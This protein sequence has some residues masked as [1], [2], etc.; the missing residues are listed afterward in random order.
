MSYSW[1]LDLPLIFVLFGTSTKSFGWSSKFI[2]SKL[3]FEKLKSPLF[4]L[5]I[6]F[7][8]NFLNN[9]YKTLGYLKKF[10]NVFSLTCLKKSIFLI[11]YIY[12]HRD[13]LFKAKYQ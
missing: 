9:N 11:I 4:N 12:I 6:L 2:E 13:A 1:M 7:F 5:S 8:Y 10:L 3:V